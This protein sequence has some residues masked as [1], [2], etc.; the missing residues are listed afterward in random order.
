VVLTVDYGGLPW[1]A[2]TLAF[3]FAAYGLVKRRP[4][5]GLSRA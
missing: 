2:L 5:S 1:I 3:S 4:M